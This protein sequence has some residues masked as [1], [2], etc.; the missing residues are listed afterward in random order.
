MFS[1]ERLAD[2]KGGRCPVSSDPNRVSTLM[3]RN[4]LSPPHPKSSH[5]AETQFLSFGS[6]HEDEI[7]NQT[8]DQKQTPKKALKE[9]NDEQKKH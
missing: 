1:N 2:L 6:V 4:S 9:L 5:P 7:K 3:F 8:S